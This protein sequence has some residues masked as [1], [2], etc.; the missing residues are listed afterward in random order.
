MVLETAILPALEV[1]TVVVQTVRV[2]AR[3]LGL[4][5]R[6]AEAMAPGMPVAARSRPSRGR[7]LLPP[8]LWVRLTVFRGLKRLEEANIRHGHGHGVSCTS[9]WT[10]RSGPW[11]LIACARANAAN[12][13]RS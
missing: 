8:T 2:A 6:R 12:A 9:L 4:G 1:R 11:W 13:D 10:S 7:S 5:A 3:T